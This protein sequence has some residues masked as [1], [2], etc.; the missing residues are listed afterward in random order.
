MA[1]SKKIRKQESE[2]EAI[3]AVA[4]RLETSK[5]ERLMC[6]VQMHGRKLTVECDRRPTKE[7]A[8]RISLALTAIQSRGEEEP[9]DAPARAE[10]S[11]AK[12]RGESGGTAGEV[13]RPTFGCAVTRS[14]RLAG[15][16]SHSHGAVREESRKAMRVALDQGYGSAHGARKTRAR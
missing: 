5:P 4:Q 6:R 9:T 7:Q 12:A 11:G 8:K 10:L 3:D 16:S 13:V 1:K 2:S 14:G 15:V